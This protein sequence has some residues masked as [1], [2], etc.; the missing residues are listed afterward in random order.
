MS[1]MEL[2]FENV[3]AETLVL[4]NTDSEYPLHKLLLRWLLLYIS[5][6]K[7]RKCFEYHWIFSRLCFLKM[8]IQSSRREYVPD[9]PAKVQ[10]PRKSVAP[11][12]RPTASALSIWH[13][14]EQYTVH[15]KQY[16][17]CMSWGCWVRQA[18]PGPP[19]CGVSVSRATDDTW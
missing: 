13:I 3:P 10:T 14:K 5:F 6:I 16:Y 19:T 15:H 8:S 18:R 11:F 17:T 2:S 1:L 4:R 9:I 12:L 7:Y